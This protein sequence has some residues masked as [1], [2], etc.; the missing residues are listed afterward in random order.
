MKAVVLGLA[1]L[2]V[3]VLM[4]GQSGLLHQPVLPQSEP[5]ATGLKE[6]RISARRERASSSKTSAARY[7]D[8]NIESVIARIEA[9]ADA[10]RQ[11]GSLDQAVGSF[12]PADL[13]GILEVLKG[14]TRPL[15]IELG[16]LVLRRWVEIDPGSSAEWAVRLADG[17]VRRLALEHV[18]VA[19]ADFDLV[20]AAVWVRSLTEGA[21][22]NTAS[23]SLAYEAARTDPLLALELATVLP[24]TRERDDLI[25]HA[26]SQ[27]AGNDSSQATA[28]A[29]MVPDS[30]LRQR[31]FAAIAVGEAEYD[32][33]A[34]AN[35]VAEMLNGTDEQ[36]RAVIAVI[37]RWAQASP[38]AAAAW[39]SQFPESAVRDAAALT[40]IDL[41]ALQ[42]P[43][44][45]G[46]WV[47]DLPTGSL[48]DVALGAYVQALTDNGAGAE[49][50]PDEPVSPDKRGNVDILP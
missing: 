11:S 6:D 16:H 14:D 23:R 12:A 37:Q 39:I 22:R 8:L 28:W 42:D 15:A 25:I 3:L 7:C 2:S 43:Q 31:L 40:L 21:D 38:S 46:L 17:E 27:W 32:G 35:L 41:W 45:S 33:A 24:P 30:I 49:P 44:S 26:A 4:A 50:A 1:S 47:H 36:D 19:W 48:R 18:V 20:A 10:G 9:E 13:P 5:L 34:A 29:A